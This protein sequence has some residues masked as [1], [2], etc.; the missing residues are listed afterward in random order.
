MTLGRNVSLDESLHLRE[1][2]QGGKIEVGPANWIAVYPQ[3]LN[4]TPA[5]VADLQFRRALVHGID[6]QAMVDALQAGLGGVAHNILVPDEADFRGVEQRA[7]R[8][9]Y[10]PRRAA[11]LMTELGY[12]RGPE[13]ELRE[14]SGERLSV[15]IRTTQMTDQQ[16]PMFAI[17]DYW[18]TLGLNPLPVVVTPQQARDRD[19]RANYPAFE[20]AGQPSGTDAL[21]RVRIS[22]IPLASNNLVG[23]NRARYQN[24]QLDD[25]IE[26]FFATI[27]KRERAEV[28]GQ[29]VN[30]MT[31]QL[32]WMS[33]YH[34]V[35]PALMSNRIANVYPRPQ[36]GSS[37]QAWNAHEWDA[38]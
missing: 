22:E 12:S 14:G 34:R 9:D 5:V 38:R 24:Q 31:D 37:S 7:V 6:R 32:V 3:F 20:L 29:I 25:L 28:L 16:K 1:Q 13:G 21:Q 27:P 8:Y 35:E 17:A 36:G 33:I 18:K 26:R 19:F 30:H 23:V 15:E 10:D 11:Q 4:P 2:Y